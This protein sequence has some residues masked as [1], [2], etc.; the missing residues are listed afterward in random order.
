[1]RGGDGVEIMAASAPVDGEDA[2][3]QD[4]T[5]IKLWSCNTSAPQQDWFIADR[6]AAPNAPVS[7]RPAGFPQTCAVAGSCVRSSSTG[8]HTGADWMIAAGTAVWS[9]CD[10]S[11]SYVT[12]PSSVSNRLVIVQCDNY[13]GYGRLNAYYG[14]ID[15]SVAQGATVSRGQR[16]G[17]ISDWSSDSH[18][19]FGLS[20]QRVTSG[21]GYAT[22]STSTPVACSGDSTR[23]DGLRPLG[24]LDADSFADA[25]GWRG[26]SSTG[27]RACP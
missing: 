4:G 9:V 23:R 16:I 8:A 26:A 19:H 2:S 25:A 12:Q 10:G 24:W 1:M 5:T 6:V 11:V 18:L 21:W 15:A 17:S 13:A 20:T 7:A 14:H 22:L 3:L 27:A